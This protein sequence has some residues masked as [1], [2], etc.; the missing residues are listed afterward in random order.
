MRSF[1]NA[2]GAGFPSSG[3]CLYYITDRKQ[4]GQP[5]PSLIARAVRRGAH[6]IQI[7][8]KDL[9]DRELFTLVRRA[10]A[11]A[12][13]TKC[14]I[15][16]NG[17]ADIALAAGAH[18]VHLPSVGLSVSDLRPWVPRQCVIGVSA[19]SLREALRAAEQGADYVLLGPVFPTESKLRYGLPLGLDCLSRVCSRVPLP[20]L[21]LGGISEENIDAVLAT[22]AAGVAGITMF[23]KQKG[24]RGKGTKG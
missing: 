11:A 19:H 10:V 12:A 4:A 3:P 22:G 20:V 15:L 9:S 8:E 13:D 6:F 2:R 5:L 17:R 1:G 14:R 18:G 21:G 24:Q 16:V 7:R 23:Q